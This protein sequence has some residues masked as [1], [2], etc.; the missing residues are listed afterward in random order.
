MEI[1]SN[2]ILNNLINPKTGNK[3]KLLIYKKVY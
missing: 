1:N 2:G 3:L